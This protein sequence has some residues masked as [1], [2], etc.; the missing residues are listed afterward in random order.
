MHQEARGQK[1]P[2]LAHTVFSRKSAMVFPHPVLKEGD[3]EAPVGRGGKPLVLEWLYGAEPFIHLHQDVM[4]EKL[5][6]YVNPLK[7]EGS[8]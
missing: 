1:W 4:E 3:F 2:G 6:Q 7:I 5:I 8:L